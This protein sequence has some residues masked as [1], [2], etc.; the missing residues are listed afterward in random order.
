MIRLSLQEHPERNYNARTYDNASKKHCDI[1][2]AF[3]TN[4]KTGGERCTMTAAGNRYIPIPYH[5]HIQR[6]ANH[7]RKGMYEKNASRLNIAGNGIYTLSKYDVDQLQANEKIYLILKEVMKTMEIKEIRSGGQTGIDQ[8]GLVAGVAL[9][10][11]TTGLYPKGYRRRDVDEV[12]YY[13]TP[14]DLR[15]EILEQAGRLS[16]TII[17]GY[18]GE[19]HCHQRP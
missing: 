19:C 3:A 17:E 4:F 12:D 11:P 6:A 8:A 15:T 9:G 7:I 14:E 16:P 10:L 1:T 13:S 18:G 2:I 5:W